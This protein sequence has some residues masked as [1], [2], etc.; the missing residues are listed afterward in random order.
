MAGIDDNGF[1]FFELKHTFGP[2]QQLPFG[3]TPSKA[4]EL[5]FKNRFYFK[6]DPSANTFEVFDQI[7]T[8]LSTGSTTK[9]DIT[10]PLGTTLTRLGKY[11]TTDA[12]LGRTNTFEKYL[13][14]FEGGYPQRSLDLNEQG[15]MMPA[16]QPNYAIDKIPKYKVTGKF[17]TPY[18]RY[19]SGV[20]D[21]EPFYPGQVIL[22]R[23][24]GRLQEVSDIAPATLDRLGGW[25][26]TGRF[27]ENVGMSTWL[28][29]FFGL[30]NPIRTAAR[31]VNQLTLP[32]FGYSNSA[33]GPN[34]IDPAKEGSYGSDIKNAINYKYKLGLKSTLIG[35]GLTYLGYKT[36][37]AF[38]NPCQCDSPGLP[39]YQKKDAFGKCTCG[40]DV[41]SSRILDPTP[42]KSNETY[43][44]IEVL[45]DSL[46]F[47]TLPP[48]NIKNPTPADYWRNRDTIPAQQESFDADFSKG[49]I[50]KKQFIK[51][52]TSK[53]QEGG[54]PKDTT[55][56]KG[57]RVDTL[58]SDIAKTKDLFK[59]KLKDNSNI[60]LT[61]EIYKNAQSN[62][63]ILNMLMQNGPKENLADDTMGQEMPTAQY[64][65]APR[66]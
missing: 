44:N 19:M 23:S 21:A 42:I 33:L 51:K 22:P 39:N 60:A 50:S 63:Q 58:T 28:P 62:P 53:F 17:N 32:T 11:L 24:V 52:F 57:S 48:F 5:T 61:E 6:T 1:Q 55:V 18:P 26:K 49:G 65:Y 16:D 8:P 40:T 3:T 36:Y 12:G 56:G 46:K 20:F 14:G 59:N 29:Q 15:Y 9:Y 13:T 37:D 43:D 64:G 41:G 7:G 54:D 4:K 25:G 66:Y 47:L 38:A 34:V 31:N 27:L 45:P 35:G 10:R 2:N 30:G